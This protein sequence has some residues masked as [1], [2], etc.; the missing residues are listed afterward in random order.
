MEEK[1]RKIER[2]QLIE[3]ELQNMMVQKQM[4]QFELSETEEA[5][6]EIKNSKEDF[7]YKIVGNL[8]IKI[9]KEESVESLEKKKKLIGLR[10]D[11]IEKQEKK[12]YEE[13]SNLREEITK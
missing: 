9:K 13:A 3:Q 10:M 4:F 1:S 11:A 5:L 2:L 12:L 8:M 7:I 6:R